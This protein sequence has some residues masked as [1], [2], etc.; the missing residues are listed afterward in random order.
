VNYLLGFT[1]EVQ[2]LGLSN[3]GTFEILFV[4]VFSFLEKDEN[5]SFP[6]SLN[7]AFLYEYKPVLLKQ[8][9]QNQQS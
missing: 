5:S 6:F 1:L 3:L 4:L 7:F 9:I 8:N 2:F